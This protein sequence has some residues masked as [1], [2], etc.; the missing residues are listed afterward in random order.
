MPYLCAMLI[1][2]LEFSRQQKE[3]YNEARKYLQRFGIYN[4]R[5]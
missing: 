4:K 3:R 5:D 2:C 1:K